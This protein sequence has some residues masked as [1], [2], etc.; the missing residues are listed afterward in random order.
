[1]CRRSIHIL[2]CAPMN[3]WIIY[4]NPEVSI[5]DLGNL[6]HVNRK[7]V[8][9]VAIDSC[10]FWWGVQANIS[11]LGCYH[12]FGCERESANQ[13]GLPH[14]GMRAL[15]VLAAATAR[16]VKMVVL[17]TGAALEHGGFVK[18]RDRGDKGP[19]DR[20]NARM[21]EIPIWEEERARLLWTWVCWW[22]WW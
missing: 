6:S 19:H 8:D 12:V 5:L 18:P 13:S 2:D 22:W 16:K 1:M 17:E 7:M 21:D 15:F 20:M 4:P 3:G 9:R 10:A 11:A 14:N